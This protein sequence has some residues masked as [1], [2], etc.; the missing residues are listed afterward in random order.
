MTEF[1]PE[2]EALPARG[3]FDGELVS[4]GSDGRPDFAAV[5][6]R[7]LNRDTAVPLTFVVF[8]LVALDGQATMALPYSERRRL[9][10]A[11]G[12]CDDRW[13][14]SPVFDDAIALWDV[15]VERE[16][17]GIVAKRLTTPYRPGER[18]WIKTKNRDYWRYG[19]EV[20]AIKRKIERRRAFV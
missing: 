5:C 19:Q 18:G 13:H 4:F 11:L 6:D 15:V 16:Y 3:I 7:I 17:E 20:E 9:L 2:L 12:L 14:V 1:V 10:D 8:D